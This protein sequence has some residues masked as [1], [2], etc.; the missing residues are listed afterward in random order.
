MKSKSLKA[1]LFVI[2]M[3]SMTLAMVVTGYGLIFLFERHA[4]RRLSVELDTYITQIAAG[5]SFGPTGTPHTASKLADPRFEKIFSGLYWQINDETSGKSAL[6]RSLWDTKLKLPDDKLG[7]GNVHVHRLKGPRNATILAHERRLQFSSAS[8]NQSVRIV[9]GIDTAELQAM[10]AQFSNEVIVA[11]I[12]LGTF[13]LIAGAIQVT[14]GLNPLKLVQKSIA[15]IRNGTS[16]RIETSVPLEI[17]PLVDEVNDLLTTQEKTLQKA[18]NRASDLAHGFKT[19]L[20]ALKTDVTRLRKKGQNKIADDIEATSLIMRRQIERELNKARIRD[21]R[22]ITPVH[23]APS[24]DQIVKTLMRTPDS[25]NKT[26]EISCER[27]LTVQMDKDDLN[28]VL[29]NL[30]ENAVKHARSKISVRV[31]QKASHTKFMIEDDGKGI[32]DQL[33]KAAQQRG[34]RLDETIAGSGLGLA[35]VGDVLDAY[36]ETLYLHK[37]PSGGLLVSFEIKDKA[38]RVPI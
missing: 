10:S 9:V 27:Q 38:G 26:F 8:G 33:R 6:S 28:E 4:E 35:I 11:L 31:C 37:S 22:A 2:Q 5:V 13:L 7:L 1:R 16:S 17:S 25:E 14:I 24:V 21:I 18:K 30:L 19:P 23:I 29:G 34:V 3:L 12:M 32:S 36:G 15:E 20:T